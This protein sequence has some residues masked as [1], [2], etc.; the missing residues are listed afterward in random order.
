MCSTYT[1][2]FVALQYSGFVSNPGDLA[3]HYAGT[4][5]AVANTLSSLSGIAAPL[6][7]SALTAH[8]RTHTCT[9]N[10]TQTLVEHVG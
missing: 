1:Q 4:V 7:A 9:H 6:V 2:M 8:V 3:P 10:V 5:Y